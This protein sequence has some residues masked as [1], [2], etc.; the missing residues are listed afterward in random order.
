M[1]SVAKNGIEKDLK[2]SFSY[3]WEC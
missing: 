1:L 3:Y 2:I